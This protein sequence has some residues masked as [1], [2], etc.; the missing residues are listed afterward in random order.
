MPVRC[1]RINADGSQ[2]EGM[3][4]FLEEDFY[5]C[6]HCDST[7]FLEGFFRC[8]RDIEGDYTCD[9]QCDHCKQYYKPLIYA[10]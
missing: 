4:D 3:L 10:L 6:C 9:L 1:K 8:Q 2:C 5:Q 7:F